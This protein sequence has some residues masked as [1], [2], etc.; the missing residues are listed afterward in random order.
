MDV[1]THTH[2]CCSTRVCTHSGAARGS[3]LEEGE[4]LPA[5]RARQALSEGAQPQP[6]V[7]GAFGSATPQGWPHLPSP[8]S[9][10]PLEDTNP[11]VK[12]PE[13]GQPR[14]NRRVTEQSPAQAF[15]RAVSVQRLP[16]KDMKEMS[17]TDPFSRDAEL[18]GWAE[19]C[20]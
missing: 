11:T 12:E 7:I 2:T 15:S 5:G 14:D 20:S 8:T 9:F 19:G 17:G 10:P 6:P 1:A 13:P 18:P 4:S 16:R 3:E